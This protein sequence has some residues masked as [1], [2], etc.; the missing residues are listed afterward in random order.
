M[1]ELVKHPNAATRKGSL[2]NIARAGK[3]NFKE[4]GVTYEVRK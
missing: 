2:D 1:T 4:R 3:F